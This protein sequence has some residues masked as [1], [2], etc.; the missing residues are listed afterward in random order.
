MQ[1]RRSKFILAALTAA[2]SLVLV[3][4]ALFPVGFGEG[5]LAEIVILGLLFGQLGVAAVWVAW[6]GQSFSLR[7]CLATAMALGVSAVLVVPVWLI[8]AGIGAIYAAILLGYWAVVQ[9]PLWVA[10]LALGWRLTKPAAGE[11]SATDSGLRFG[12][13]HLLGWTLAVALLLSAGRWLMP[14]K[15]Y[16]QGLIAFGGEVVVPILTLMTFTMLTALC[17]IAAGLVE[18]KLWLWIPVSL[19]AVAALILAMHAVSA[20]RSDMDS[21]PLQT[22]TLIAVQ[23]GWLLGSMVALRLAGYR[24]TRYPQGGAAD[25]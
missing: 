25:G 14:D 23:W 4:I 13:K 1:Q 21:D 6:G 11:S 12:L 3:A 18:Q 22:C 5:Q 19:A 16:F 24:L 9:M 2:H 7:V 10:R 8:F 17:A 15:E 20:F